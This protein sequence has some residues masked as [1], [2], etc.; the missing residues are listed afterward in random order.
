MFRILLVVSILSLSVA[1]VSNSETYVSGQ[2][3]TDTTWTKAGSPYVIDGIVQVGP[4]VILQIEPGVEVHGTSTLWHQNVL[5]VFGVLHA[6][7]NTYTPISFYN[8]EVT[9]KESQHGNSAYI[10]I[11]GCNF[12]KG[13]LSFGGYGSGD[14]KNSKFFN[15]DDYIY[16]WYPL[17]DI[18]IENNEFDQFPGISVGVDD[19][20]VIIRNNKFNKVKKL[21]KDFHIKAWNQHSG[22][23]VAIN[24]SFLDHEQV[25]I[26]A[27]ID[28][29]VDARNNYWGTTDETVIA[30]MI[31]DYDDDFSLQ[32]IPYK[33]FL[34]DP[35]KWGANPMGAIML[36]L[37]E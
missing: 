29:K 35:P 37:L 34:A 15:M 32:V 31:Y 20:V 1:A 12:E 6:N 13:R 16:I 11:N 28:G 22:K 24:N 5:S 25:N 14:I 27:E 9:Y 10:E 3:R 21:Y 17:S 19:K 7:G 8:V 33:P 36:L 4:G 18:V 2:I 23:I 26:R 30:K